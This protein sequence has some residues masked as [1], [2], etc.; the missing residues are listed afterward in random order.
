[1]KLLKGFIKTI[2]FIL[3]FIFIF[4]YLSNLFCRK[5]LEG[6][7]N[8]TQKI[9]GF[10]NE[11][12][13]EF[14]VMF[15]GSSN[16]YCSFNPLVLYEHTG[17]KSYVFASQQQPAWATYTYIKEA[18]KTQKPQLLVVDVLMFSKNE[19]F[20]D[21]GVIYSYMD[22]IP[23]SKNKIELAAVSAPKGE[24]L[25]L[26]VNFI[27]YHSRW[28]SLVREDWEFNRK[29]TRDFLKGYTL[30]E[31]TFTEGVP[32]VRN[33]TE[34]LPLS[35]KELSCFYKIIELAKEDNIPLF[36]VKTPSNADKNDQMLFNSIEKLAK[37]NNIEFVNY[38]NLYD[39]IGLDMEKDFYD[40]SHLNRRG[41]EVF[42]KY[43]AEHV[44]A[45]FPS[46]TPVDTG[47]SEL[48]EADLEKYRNLSQMPL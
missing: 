46:L 25:G 4:S 14:D 2:I 32:P 1:M 39:E 38:N 3:I 37:E 12:E 21:D 33:V 19:E 36:F 8:Q 23:L 13:N 7:W 10:Y 24:R 48:W 42:T 20:Y 47:T 22:D 41:A 40:K 28:S 30:L 44:T 17:L 29:E 35:E 6:T 15:F 45:H 26:L 18:L 16:T 27:K 31:D 34:C 5:A 9:S 11:P 43:F